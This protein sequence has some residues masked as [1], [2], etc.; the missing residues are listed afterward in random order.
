MN[1]SIECPCGANIAIDDASEMSS[2]RV[3]QMWFDAHKHH[4][5]T[6]EQFKLKL[7]KI[8]SGYHS[9]VFE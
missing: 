5:I 7:D 6:M 8:H 4:K 3:I 1:I 9:E 2:D